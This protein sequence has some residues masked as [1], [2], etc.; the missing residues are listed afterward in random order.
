MTST[1]APRI[2]RV[3]RPFA[4]IATDLDGTLLRSD[5]TVGPRT[6]AALALATGRG[7]RHVVVTGRSVAWTRPVLDA[8]DYTGLAVCGQGGQVYDADA[9]REL[10]SVTLD[11]VIAAEAVA[12][13]ETEVGPLSLAAD[14]AGLDGQVLTGPGYRHDPVGNLPVVPVGD[15]AGL[16]AAPVRK[17][18]VQHR[19][20]DE[21]RLAEA[22]LRAAGH[23]VGVTKAG[24]GEVELLPRGLDKSTGLAFVARRLGL[25]GG[26]TIAFGD[27]PNDAPMLA[28][29]GHGVA[30]A[31][32]HPELLAVADEV[33]PG[34]DADGV[35]V[36]LQRLY[37]TRP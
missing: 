34:H 16:W 29:A 11:R 13:I 28:W 30:M 2:D 22:A 26:D 8:L 19:T 9:H 17:F 10:T 24:P 5:H 27:M 4:L 14:L 15:R 12:K 25:T 20:L 35:G 33:A 31:G 18:Y 6:R 1:P 32:A 7:A 21:E 23:L 36:V 37:G 3:R